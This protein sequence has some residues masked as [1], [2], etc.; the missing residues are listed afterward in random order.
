MM[1]LYSEG[2]RRCDES[3]QQGKEDAYEEVLK[4]FLSYSSANSLNGPNFKHVSVNEFFNFISQKLQDH[5][6]SGAKQSRSQPQPVEVR[7]EAIDMLAEQ[8]EL[9]AKRA[10]R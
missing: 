6:K 10:P 2:I 5:R 8:A 1:S 3:Y 4:W 7:N 9:E